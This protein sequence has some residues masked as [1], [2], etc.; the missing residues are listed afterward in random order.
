MP[1]MRCL[2]MA[3]RSR[4][5]N[6][7]S[8]SSLC[9]VEAQNGRLQQLRPSRQPCPLGL[10]IRFNYQDKRGNLEVSPA[11]KSA[12]EKAWHAFCEAQQPALQ[13]TLQLAHIRQVIRR[14]EGLR[15]RPTAASRPGGKWQSDNRHEPLRIAVSKRPPAYCERAAGLLR[16]WWG[17]PSSPWGKS[18]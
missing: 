12:E 17:R 15:G 11:D 16:P 10:Q 3:S 5:H 13:L 18:F 7:G 2:D 6:G 4:T 14:W 9:T 1:G 8:R